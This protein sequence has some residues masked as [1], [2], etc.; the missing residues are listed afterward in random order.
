MVKLSDNVTVCAMTLRLV[1]AVIIR[2]KVVKLVMTALRLARRDI[3]DRSVILVTQLVFASKMTMLLPTPSVIVTMFPVAI[4]LPVK[5]VILLRLWLEMVKNVTKVLAIMVLL[6]AVIPGALV[7]VAMVAHW[8]RGRRVTMVLS[9]VRRV[10]VI[11][12]VVVRRQHRA[13]M[14]H[15]SW[16][17]FV[18]LARV[19]N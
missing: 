5:P 16:V 11:V 1:S 15:K 19:Q 18:I 14:A 2:S 8:I 6:V 7:P 9:M 10:N 3:A 13:V 17:R 12:P 4:V